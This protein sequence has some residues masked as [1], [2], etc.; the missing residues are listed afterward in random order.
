[1]GKAPLLTSPAKI[2]GRTGRHQEDETV[3][4]S[5]AASAGFLSATL[6]SGAAMAARPL[7][8]QIGFQDAASPV[9]AEIN[10]FHNLLLVIITLITL[11]VLGL[12]VYVMWRFNEKRN[13][14]PSKT[15]HSTVLEVLWTAI[16][17][18]ILVIIF[19]PSMK[20][21]YYSDRATDAEMTLKV[22]GSQ[23]YWS[24]EY[25]DHGD[26]AFDSYLTCRTQEEC[27]DAA[28]DGNKPLRLLDVDNRVVLPVDTTIRILVTA[29]DVIHNFAMPALGLKMDA[30][31]GRT[32]ETWTRILRPGVYYGQCSELCGIDHAYMP[33]AIEAVSKDDFAK[34]VETA[35][36]E[37]VEAAYERL[38]RIKDA[39]PDNQDVSVARAAAVE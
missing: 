20:L 35:R 18:V 12:L 38:A 30:V 9:M 4:R 37:G 1:V 10:W 19:I 23:W 6:A 14:T 5:I 27:D 28:K 22:V 8:W 7:P 11:F 15:T 31:P 33:I 2:L 24:Y 29:R 13:P 36:A 32:N 39:V 21:L 17:V 26:V 34:W 3:G 16:P 25:P